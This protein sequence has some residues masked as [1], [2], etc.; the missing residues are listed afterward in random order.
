MSA[1]P[2]SPFSS[3]VGYRL[4][5]LG[6]RAMARAEAALVDIGIKPRHLNVLAVIANNPGLSQREISALVGLDPNIMVG[7]IDDLE[8]DG[9]AV[10]Q[11][12]TS[13]RRRYVVA[14]TGKGS[15]VLERG[16]RALATGEEEF[17]TPLS[18][19]QRKV[20]LDLCGLLLEGD[21]SGA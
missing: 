9:F 15:D 17:L 5:K 2:V 7:V 19:E 12:S 11:R 21:G 20:L 10:R 1:E 18:P 6:E 13:D 4:V 8:G 3:G 16:M 14:M